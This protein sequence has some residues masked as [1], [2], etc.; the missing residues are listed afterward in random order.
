MFDPKYRPEWEIYDEG[1]VFEDPLTRLRGMQAYRR[2]IEFLRESPVFGE[3]QLLLHDLAVHEPNV[4][5]TRWTLSL[6]AKFVPFQPLVVFTGTSTYEWSVEHGRIVSHVDRWD[7]IS[8]QAYFS[9]EGLR[10]L[11]AQ[12]FFRPFQGLEGTVLYRF[13]E[14]MIVQLQEGSV[15]ARPV[16]RRLSTNELERGVEQTFAIHGYQVTE[17]TR[18]DRPS[19]M[20]EWL[21]LH[22]VDASRKP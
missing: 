17:H 2:N 11:L 6:R 8:R 1:I 3:G 5:V 13:R 9:P 10:D 18:T 15:I 7:S 4:V 16:Y 21:H 20:T 14:F 12:L 22:K 19:E